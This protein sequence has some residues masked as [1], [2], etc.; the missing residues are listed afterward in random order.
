[1]SLGVQFVLAQST[2]TIVRFAP[3]VVGLRDVEPS[4]LLLR[5]W[6]QK[7]DFLLRRVREVQSKLDR[8]KS[9]GDSIA[10]CR[11]PGHCAAIPQ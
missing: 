4:F 6:P 9:N 2:A 3:S 10:R 7:F 11:G 5:T 8:R 1:M